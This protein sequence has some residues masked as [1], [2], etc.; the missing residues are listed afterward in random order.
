MVLT[1]IPAQSQSEAIDWVATPALTQPLKWH[2]GKYFLAK[3]IL[4][5]MPPHTHY[6]ETHLGGGAVLLGKNP[7]GISEVV[8]DLDGDLTNFWR[9]LQDE[10][11]FN[12]FMRQIECMPFSQVEWDDAATQTG[13]TEV[14]RA[15]RF[16]VFCRQSR[17]GRMLEFA[18]VAKSR[19]SRKMNEHVSAWWSAVEGLPEVHERLKRVVILNDDA[20]KVIRKHDSPNTL[21]YCDPPYLHS[22]RAAKNAYRFEMTEDDHMELL[23]LLNEAEGKVILSGYPSDLYDSMLP[24]WKR[25]DC[26]MANHASGEKSKRRMTE[27]L[28][29]NY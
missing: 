20:L 10:G 15:V 12:E 2:G 19:I 8:N 18:T 25:I 24:H 14:D 9:V 17:A 5:L 28:W 29:L 22:T 21:F 6:V 1:E 13:G 11:T 23:A 26:D 16:F 7:E 4:G 3:R 27:C